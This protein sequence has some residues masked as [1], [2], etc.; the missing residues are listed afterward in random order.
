MASIKLWT[1]ALLMLTLVACQPAR[2]QKTSIRVGRTRA[3]NGVSATSPSTIDLSD[4]VWG[5]I[6]STNASVWNQ[7]IV[8]FATP[9]LGAADPDDQQLGSV[10]AMGTDNTG[11]LFYGNAVTTGGS[12]YTRQFDPAQTMIHIEIYDSLTGQKRSDGTPRPPVVIEIS[13]QLNGKSSGTISG[14]NGSQQVSLHFEDGYGGIDMVGMVDNT[15]FTGTISYCNLSEYSSCAQ[16]TNMK[17]LGN[18]QVE[19][20]GFFTCL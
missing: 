10:N 11:V 2:D 20:C 15:M 16:G 5:G 18:F 1:L 19:K 3:G 14:A 17:V 13:P 9:S 8:E 4:K 7:E 6:T 12:A